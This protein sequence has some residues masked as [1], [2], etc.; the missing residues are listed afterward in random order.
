[1][2]FKLLATYS[3]QPSIR[4]LNTCLKAPDKSISDVSFSLFLKRSRLQ[5]L[6]ITALREQPERHAVF[7]K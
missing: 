6:C 3:Y 4:A 7:G 2:R 1:M 5:K